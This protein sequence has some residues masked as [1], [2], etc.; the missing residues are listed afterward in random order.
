MALHAGATRITELKTS[1]HFFCLARTLLFAISSDFNK[2][3]M[4]E[5]LNILFFMK[6]KKQALEKK[7]NCTSNRY[8]RLYVNS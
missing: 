4:R 8:L 5:K 2:N 6:L 1:Y 3:G 7:N